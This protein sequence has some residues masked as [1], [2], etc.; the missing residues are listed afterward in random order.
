MGKSPKTEGE[1]KVGRPTKFRDNLPAIAEAL[2]AEGW[3][4]D[5]IAE[6]F[7]VSRSTVYKWIDELQEFSDAIKRG[8]RAA[9]DLVEA[10]HLKAAVGYFVPETRL[11]QHEGRVIREDI[12]R[13]IPGDVRAQM[14]WLRN[15]DPHAWGRGEGGQPL[16]PPAPADVA[17]AQTFAEFC[18]RA[19]YPI[20]FDKQE[21]MRAFTFDDESNASRLLLGSRGY[22]KTDYVTILGTAWEIYRRRGQGPHGGFRA[23]VLTKSDDR[24][25]AII[26]EITKAL[27]ANGASLEAAT[28]HH[29]REASLRGKDHSVEALTVGSNAVRGHHP[30]I[31]LLDDPVTEEDVSE[32]TRRKLERKYNELVKLKANIVLIGQPVHVFDLYETLRP[33]VRVMEV[34]HGTIPELDHDLVAMRLAGVSETSINASYHLKVSS[35]TGNPLSGVSWIDALPLGDSVAFI[36]PSFKGGDYTAMTIG[37]AHFDGIAVHGYAWK[38]AWDACLDDIAKACAEHNVRRLGFECNSLGTMP[39]PIL[40]AK[41]P[42]VGVSGK[43][44]TGFKHSRIMAAGTF[45]KQIHVSKQSMQIWKDQVVK[46]EYGSKFDDSPDSLASL[47]EWIGL[48]R[49]KKR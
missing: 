31:V 17:P 15:A 7:G 25:K 32:A 19:G 14:N 39:L 11:F 12:M 33:L 29:V 22:G 10:A 48:I 4:N 9:T 6:L 24:N 23:L 20:P 41:L 1:P 26:A 16:L 43:D 5:R 38:K 18:Q 27:V 21:E 46:Y 42:G 30:D 37:R 40:R 3:T 44:S 36:D 2:K 49:G 28:T 34:P 35:E 8:R 13:F 45:A 47:L